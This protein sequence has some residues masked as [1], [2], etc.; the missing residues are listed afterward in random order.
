MSIINKCPSCG[1]TQITVRRDI[2]CAFLIIVFVSFG[3][4]LIMIPFLPKTYTCL[5]CKTQWK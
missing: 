5:K 1:A 3:F 4:G 2:G